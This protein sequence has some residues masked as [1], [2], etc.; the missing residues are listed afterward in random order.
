L[1][2][3]IDKGHFKRAAR[4]AAKAGFRVFPIRP[5]SKSPAIKG[6]KAKASND[7]NAVDAFWA[8]HPDANIGVAAGGKLGLL[9]LDVD[10]DDRRQSLADLKQQH[11]RLPRTVKVLTPHGS[12]YYFR[13]DEPLRNSVR[14]LAAG[15]DVRA[16]GGCVVGADSQRQGSAIPL[17]RGP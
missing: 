10:G 17:C 1:E 16:G 11:G 5:G 15:L 9:V 3:R 6:W 12:H 2:R 8:D 14:K 4:A 13:T 7:K